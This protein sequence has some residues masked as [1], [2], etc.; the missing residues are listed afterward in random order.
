[1]RYQVPVTVT[2]QANSPDEAKAAVQRLADQAGQAYIGGLRVD[3]FRFTVGA[4]VLAEAVRTNRTAN[5]SDDEFAV[6]QEAVARYRQ[7]N[8]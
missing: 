3:G 6:A 5:L 2:L 8:G 1:M 4:A 7:G